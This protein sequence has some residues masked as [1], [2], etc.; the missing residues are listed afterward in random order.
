MSFKDLEFIT[1]GAF[2]A[3][4]TADA[5]TLAGF[6]K[7]F[8]IVAAGTTLT[9]DDTITTRAAHNCLY[10]YVLPASGRLLGF[11][12]DLIENP[13][14]KCEF[15][16]FIWK[17]DGTGGGAADFTTKI[18]ASTDP[19]KWASGYFFDSETKITC[20]KGDYLFAAQK[21]PNGAKKIVHIT[22]YIRYE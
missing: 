11:T 10:A 7:S 14:D 18:T 2:L 22:A 19:E 20:K 4:S 21:V 13:G 3:L 1:P 5:T 17:P 15:Y 9:A 8:P 16:C 6:P 12:V